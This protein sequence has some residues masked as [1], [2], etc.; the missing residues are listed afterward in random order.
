MEEYFLF[1]DESGTSNLKNVDANFPVL[2]LTGV[3][4]S[5]AEYNYLIAEVEKLKKYFFGTTQ[6][7]LHDRDIRKHQNGFE[8]L[9]IEKN[10]LAFWNR[11]SSIVDKTDFKIVSSVIDKREHIKRYGFIAEDPYPLALTFI[12]ERTVIETDDKNAIV[13]VIIE[14]RGKKENATICD[15]YSRLLN[16]GTSYVTKQRFDER[17][18]STMQIRRK[19]DYEIGIELADLCAYPIAKHILDSNSDGKFYEHISKK[20]RANNKGIVKGYG[21]KV[22]P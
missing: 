10:E 15:R 21:I 22:F 8:S 12:L 17:L 16:A 6:I 19:N 13:Q 5:S 4:I 20:I 7:V 14:G 11:M 2:A 1:M 9:S 18:V 3:L